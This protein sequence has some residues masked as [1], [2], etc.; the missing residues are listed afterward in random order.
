MPVEDALFA[1]WTRPPDLLDDPITRFGELYTEPVRINGTPM[2]LD[3]LVARARGLH[4]AFTEH[5]IEL[6]DRI[7]SPRKLA[8]AF[9]HRARHSGPWQ[10]P[11][12]E[13]APTGRIVTGLGIDLLTFTEHRISSIWV[14]ADE[15]Q[16]MIQ[17]KLA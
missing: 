8:I 5:D 2:S 11:L 17:V 4:T 10:T 7:E 14:L 9:R 1:L 15:L 16:R 3:D 12:G 6:V 13:L